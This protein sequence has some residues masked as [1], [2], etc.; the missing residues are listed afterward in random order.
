[1]KPIIH[2]SRVW[3]APAVLAAAAL[4]ACNDEGAAETRNIPPESETE[5]SAPP[6]TGSPGGQST[7]RRRLPARIAACADVLTE[8]GSRAPVIARPATASA[9]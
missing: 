8:R 1:M 2:K 6:E 9:G 5:T 7:L 3:L 4:L